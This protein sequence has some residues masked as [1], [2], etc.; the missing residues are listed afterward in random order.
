MK[1]RRLLVLR[2]VGPV[3]VVGFVLIS[4]AAVAQT[5]PTSPKPQA[6]S[7][8]APPTTTTTIQ[9]IGTTPLPGTGIDRDKVPANVQ[10]L[11]SSDLASEGSAS[12]I[13][14]LTDQAGSVNV[15][16]TLDDPFQ[17][18]ILFRGFTASPVLGTRQ[19]MAV[20]QNGLRINEA[21]GDTVN[22]DLIPDIAIDRVDLISSNPVYGLNA[23]GGGVI[24]AMKDGFSHPGFTGEVSGGSFGQRGGVFEYGQPTATRRVAQSEPNTAVA[25]GGGADATLRTRRPTRRNA[26]PSRGKR[27]RLLNHGCH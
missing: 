4:T 17:P 6:A 10:S 20:Y 9:V 21:F 13:N 27:A 5:S 25:A 3:T 2:S 16:A 26:G 11:T 8:Q 19:G 1:E 18:D 14:G 7:P 22:W 12:V 24:V 23:L 15:N